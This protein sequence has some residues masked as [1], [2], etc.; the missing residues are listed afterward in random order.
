MASKSTFISGSGTGFGSFEVGC[1]LPLINYCLILR[2][3]HTSHK[4]IVYF[5]RVKIIVQ[6]GFV[7]YLAKTRLADRSNK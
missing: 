3:S 5:E 1:F 4:L 6:F 2:N 7:E